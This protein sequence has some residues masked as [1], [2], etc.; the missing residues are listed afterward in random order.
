ME[1]NHMH[2]IWRL[3]SQII[4]LIATVSLLSCV[5]LSEKQ[6]PTFAS[7]ED[8]QEIIDTAMAK[9]RL[10]GVIAGIWVNDK[11]Y[12][13]QAKGKADISTGRDIK[14]YDRVRIG[15]ITK[16]FVSTVLLQLVDEKKIQLDDRLDKYAP[17]VPNAQDITIRQLLNHTSGL[18]D[19]EQIIFEEPTTFDPLKKWTVQ[20]LLVRGL[21]RNPYFAPGKGWHYSNTGY[22]LIGMIMEQI[23][24]HTI[25]DEIKKRIIVPLALKNTSVPNGP[26]IEGEYAHGYWDQNN[27][28]ILEDVSRFDPS[29]EWVVGTMISSLDDL[30]VWSDA[31][32][33]GKLLSK[34]MH[35]E[36]MTW[37]NT[38]PND[39]DSLKYGLGIMKIGGMIGHTG[40]VPGYE[41]A[42]FSIPEKKLKIIILINRFGPSLSDSYLLPILKEFFLRTSKLNTK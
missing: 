35:D 25:D 3:F 2:G 27:N 33:Q 11:K 22:I 32:I 37:A 34:S 36:Q 7:P 20:E 17:Y 40:A 16:T 29:C 39:P 1:T 13:I 24:G 19:Y 30:S 26:D 42:M 18:Y 41:T 10:P 23:T 28:G 14:P 21:S 6:Q 31:L 9:Y 15:S 38:D 4:C 8:F 5:G 12:W